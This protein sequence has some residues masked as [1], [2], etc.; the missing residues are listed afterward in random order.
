MPLCQLL[1]SRGIKQ[2]EK[3]YCFRLV[4]VVEE[5]ICDLINKLLYF[6]EPVVV[7][8]FVLNFNIHYTD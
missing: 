5:I 7:S 8:I 6:V 3:F 1:C 4:L 2:R